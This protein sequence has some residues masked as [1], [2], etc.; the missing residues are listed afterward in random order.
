MKKIFVLA[1][2]LLGLYPVYAQTQK[3]PLQPG[4]IYRLQ[5]VGDAHVSPD[6]KW[7]VYTISTIDSAKDKRNSDVWMSSWDGK[8]QVQLTSSPESESQPRWSPDGKYISFMAARKEGKSQV[9]LL[10]RRGGEAKQLTEAK[11]SLESYAWSPDGKMLAL[12]MNDP[13]DTAKNKP[14]KPYV[15]NRYSFKRDVSGY[16]YDTLRTHLYLFDVAGKHMRPLTQGIW[17]EKDLVW[18]PDGARIAF[19]SNRSVDK[20]K[21]ENTDIWI[22]DTVAGAMP[23]QLTTWSGSDASPVWSPDGKHLAYLRTTSDAAYEM[24]DET[25]LCVVAAE[26]GTPTLLSDRLDRPV[27]AP[28]WTADGKSIAALVEDDMLQYVA[29][30][31]AV[32]GNMQKLVA[33]DRAFTYLQ[34]APQGRWITLMS[35]MQT[36]AELYVVENGALRRVTQIQKKFLDSLVLARG[37]KFV[38]ISKDSTRVSGVIYYP[39]GKMEKSLPAIFY[40]HGGPTAQDELS[41]DLTRQMLAAQGYAVIG[42]NYRGSNGRGVAYSRAISGDWGNKEV[43]DILGAADFLVGKGVLDSTRMAMSGWSY[44]GILTDYVIATTQRFKAASSG[45]GVAAPLS[46]FG[47]DQYINQYVNELGLPWKDNNIEKY[48]KLSYPFLHADRITTPTQFMVGEKDFNVPAAGSE[49]MYQ[50]LRILDIPTELIVYP[51]Q[52]H[53]FTQPSFIKDRY[54]RYIAWFNKYLQ[55]AGA[56]VAGK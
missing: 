51:N 19:V 42:V 30:F 2:M 52:Y 35:D 34:P 8:E 55:P 27:M 39:P 1:S 22:V 7:I 46:L 15:I 50:A 47:V 49:Q 12:T 18:S 56:V 21:N 9:Y 44:G 38:S 32:T 40:I 6:G 33:G 31:N 20:D 13:E 53:G 5:S 36:P 48:L 26:G 24:Y 14:P 17:E 28:Q 23:R 43:M 3:R 29:L 25:G 37:E 11:G 41:F 45:A 16:L 10:D 4:D 54:E